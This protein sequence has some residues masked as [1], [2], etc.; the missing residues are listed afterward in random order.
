MSASSIDGEWG[1]AS[2]VLRREYFEGVSRN[3][4]VSPRLQCT[5]VVPFDST[6]IAAGSTESSSTTVFKLAGRS[7]FRTDRLGDRFCRQISGW[8]LRAGR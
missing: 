6:S 7:E 5:N 3:A 8:G 1:R 2:R 4:A